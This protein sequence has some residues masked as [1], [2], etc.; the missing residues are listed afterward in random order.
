MESNATDAIFVYMVE[1]VRFQK[2]ELADAVKILPDTMSNKVMTI[3]DQLILEGRQ[4]GKKEGIEQGIAQSLQTTVLNAFDN[5]VEI[6][7]IR[8]I[9]GET[10]EKINAIL[11]QNKRI[12]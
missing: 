8:L 1:G 7:L 5:G 10:E 3:Y 4:L 6:P 9:T 12:R 11:R 2:K